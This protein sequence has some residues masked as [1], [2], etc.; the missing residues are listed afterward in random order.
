MRGARWLEGGACLGLV[1]L[2]AGC[3]QSA[4]PGDLLWFEDVTD[5]AGLAFIH[6]SVR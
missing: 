2:L 5:E 4:A 3:R 1:V 6:D